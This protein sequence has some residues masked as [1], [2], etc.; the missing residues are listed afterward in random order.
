MAAKKDAWN[1]NEETPDVAQACS[2]ALGVLSACS[3]NTWREL[4]DGL[5]ELSGPVFR[6]FSQLSFLPWQEELLDEYQPEFQYLSLSPLQTLSVCTTCDEWAVT[7]SKAIP[8]CLM[9]L[10][11]SGVPVK[12]VSAKKTENNSSTLVTVS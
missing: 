11:C 12:I 2:L 5:D 6:K 1:I 9:T 10:G 3:V 4:C 8:K 7:D